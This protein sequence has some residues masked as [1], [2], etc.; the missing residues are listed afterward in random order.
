MQQQENYNVNQSIHEKEKRL[1]LAVFS[2]VL[3]VLNSFII[4]VGTWSL[5]VPSGTIFDAFLNVM[6]A[7]TIAANIFFVIMGH[8]YLNFNKNKQAAQINWFFS[9][10]LIGSCL[11]LMANIFIT[12]TTTLV[13][14]PQSSLHGITLTAGIAMNA[15]THLMQLLACA[16]VYK[17][18]RSRPADDTR[19]I[20]PAWNYA[21]PV[22]DDA[23]WTFKPTLTKIL[24]V[25]GVC[26]I[27]LVY[28]LSIIAP[29]FFFGQGPGVIYWVAGDLSMT[30]V[31]FLVPMTIIMIRHV[32]R[33]KLKRD[34]VLLVSFVIVGCVLV[35]IN[36]V[37]IVQT[38]TT[39]IPSLDRQFETAF[40]SN[41][42]NK[43]P[44]KVRDNFRVEA[45]SLKDMLY[46]MPV[47]VVSETFNVTYMIDK[48]LALKFDWYGPSG[49]SATSAQLPVI[50]ALHPG[51]WR[52]YDKGVANNFPVSQYLASEGYIVVDAQYGL[53]NGSA[54][55]FTLRDMIRE[56]GRLTNYLALNANEFHVNVSRAFFLGRSAGAHLSLVAGLGYDNPFFANNFSISLHCLG[57]IP[58]YAPT[59]MSLFFNASEQILFGV[60]PSEFQFFN[61]VDLV[62]PTSPPVLCFQGL[63]DGLVNPLNAYQLQD[64]MAARGRTCI[65][66]MF[67]NDGHEFDVFYN[68]FYDQVC[69]YYIERFLAILTN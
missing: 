45:I 19:T 24:K 13:I 32:P 43:I 21:R 3:M 47:P 6:L 50:I 57:I 58:Y 14:D 36:L 15:V 31:L 35:G 11:M 17:I 39:T 64:A 49:V 67:P 37:P 18:A 53:Y 38:M 56:I 42:E 63:A 51:S 9:G 29:T 66:G 65:L 22:V 46:T 52:Y 48:G 2:V 16:G 60:S 41:W 25:I 33:T 1:F 61:P 12:L 20:E 40:G 30:F 28:V 10:Y 27:F 34:R 69:V 4:F 8:V 23:S 44:D 68:Y 5:V 62:S 7:I 59:N 54:G 26:F 55:T